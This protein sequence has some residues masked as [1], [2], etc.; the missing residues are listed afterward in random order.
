VKLIQ[1][2]ML[3]LLLAR[4]IEQPMGKPQWGVFGAFSG[5]SP[6]QLTAE[7]HSSMEEAAEAFS[8]GLNHSTRRA[9]KNQRRSKGV[10]LKASEKRTIKNA[11][12]NG[13]RE[14]GNPRPSERS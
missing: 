8:S 3:T 9:L 12:T 13:Q 14:E 4:D 11:S 2:R 5:E 6:V 7:L 10:P 1:T